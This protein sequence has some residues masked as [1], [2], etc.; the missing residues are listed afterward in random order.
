MLRK[1][2]LAG[3]LGEQTRW[4]RELEMRLGHLFSELPGAQYHIL[5]TCRGVRKTRFLSQ[6]C[7]KSRSHF[8]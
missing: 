7:H 2:L 5:I 3:K 8:L 1:C 6:L 4:W